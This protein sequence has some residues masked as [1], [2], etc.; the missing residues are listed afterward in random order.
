[1]KT[2]VH[3]NLVNI[4]NSFVIISELE[5]TQMTTQGWTGKHTWVYNE[6]LLV[7]L[8]NQPI[9]QS[10]EKCNHRMEPKILL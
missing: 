1:M 7:K 3:T 4:H 2:Y 10:T 8:I 6:I 5:T 9:N